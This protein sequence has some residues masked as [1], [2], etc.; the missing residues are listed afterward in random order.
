[1]VHLYLSHGLG[2]NSTA[3]MLLLEDMNFEFESVFVDTGAEMPET[4]EYLDYLRENGFNIT[5][6][7]PN[8]EGFSSL[9]DYCKH[10]KKIPAQFRRW[11]TDKFKI[12]P[13]NNYAKKPC[14]KFLAIA[15]DEKHRVY[16]IKPTKGVVN[17]YPLIEY[18]IT[19]KDCIRIIE[20]HGLRVPE[21]SHCFICPF[22]NKQDLK[23]L[24]LEHP[25]LYELRKQLQEEATKQAGKPVYYNTTKIDEKTVSLNVFNL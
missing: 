4:Y 3:L 7:K 5:V 9:L 20:K 12:R 21:R 6:I 16:R 17:A 18:K 11:C 22:M 24:Q 19:R 10:H 14:V 13:I 15:Y 2:V 25:D 1:M 8:T 23:R